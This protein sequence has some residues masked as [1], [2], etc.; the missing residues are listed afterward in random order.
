MSRTHN[1][2]LASVKR[3]KQVS[4]ESDELLRSISQNIIQDEN[5]REALADEGITNIQQASL[6]GKAVFNQIM[7]VLPAMIETHSQRDSSF[8][9][10]KEAY[11][12][13]MKTC[14]ET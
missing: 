1:M 11:D 13:S 12:R 2:T 8:D 4:R 5:A 6:I 7:S 14:A 10:A 9:E 3:A